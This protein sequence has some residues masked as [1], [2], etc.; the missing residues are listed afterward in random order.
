MSYKTSE[1]LP[2]SFEATALENKD[3]NLSSHPDAVDAMTTLQHLLLP[4]HQ[5]YS[6][7]PQ[8]LFSRLPFVFQCQILE[9]HLSLEAI[10]HVPDY[11]LGDTLP[12]T[13]LHYVSPFQEISDVEI[14]NSQRM[15]RSY[16]VPT[17]RN[18]ETEL[19]IEYSQVDF[20][21]PKIHRIYFESQNG[22]TGETNRHSVL[23]SQ[24]EVRVDSNFDSA[25]Y[26]LSENEIILPAMPNSW[27]FLTLF[28][29]E[30]G[31]SMD[32]LEE[33]VQ[34]SR[35]KLQFL[36]SMEGLASVSSESCMENTIRN[37]HP[38]TWEEL[39]APFSVLDAALIYQEEVRASA[40]AER[41]LEDMIQ[42]VGASTEI[43]QLIQRTYAD[44]LS[45]YLNLILAVVGKTGF[46]LLEKIRHQ[47]RITQLNLIDRN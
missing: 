11:S 47:R 27:F 18:V 13:L 17:D 15:L 44:A 5:V 23:E 38:D 39:T 19:C 7:I 43:L 9:K 40:Y 12:E 46:V 37:A 24:C 35:L 29:H 33:N 2:Y 1:R 22:D 26:S 42:N 10:F 20:T 16:K 4:Q 41:L 25:G 6:E 14:P 28:G 30:F 34:T 8:E 21:E 31:H 3:R 32:K 45:T 36:H